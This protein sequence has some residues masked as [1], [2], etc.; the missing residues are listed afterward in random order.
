MMPNSYTTRIILLIGIVVVV[1]AI[2]VLVPSVYIPRH[3]IPLQKKEE[4]RIYDVGR[5]LTVINSD[6]ALGGRARSLYQRGYSLNEAIAE[7]VAAEV[8]RWRE[9]DGAAEPFVRETDSGRLLLVDVNG[10]PYVF[11]QTKEGAFFLITDNPSMMTAPTPPGGT[12]S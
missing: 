11:G 5:L 9:R 6:S 4:R 10:I 3:E 1:I 8:P 12:T 2:I 7:V